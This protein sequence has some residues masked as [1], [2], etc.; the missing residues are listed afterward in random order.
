MSEKDERHEPDREKRLP[1]PGLDDEPDRDA[2][3]P[4]VEQPSRPALD[5][6]EPAEEERH[7]DS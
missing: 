4:T 2:G 3:E 7:F 5:P 1:Q 6:E